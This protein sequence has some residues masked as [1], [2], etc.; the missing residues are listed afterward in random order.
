[1]TTIGEALRRAELALAPV[2]GDDARIEADVLL[3]HV[4]GVD[5]AHLL[6]S[7]ADDLPDERGT[8]F[9]ALV[10][11]RFAREPLS[12]VVGKTDFFSID[13]V[14]TPAALIPRWETEM[15]V[16]FALDEA[17]SRGR[18]VRV[19]DVGTGTGA[20]AVAIAANAL[21][22]EVTATD[23]STE[24]LA[25]ARINVDRNDA[26]ERVTLAHTDLLDGLGAFDV[27]VANLPYISETEWV[28]LPTEIHEHEPCEALVGGATGLEIIERLLLDAP[29]HLTAGGV[30]AAEIGDTHGNA[31][32]ALGR[33]CF[34]AAD[35]CVMKDLSGLDRML[36]VRT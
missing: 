15:L 32:L 29:S 9:H 2:S 14:C 25:L 33:A 16:G 3:A 22:V 36:V 6:A 5:R 23:S 28:D 20:I 27:I 10:A 21:N 4:L 17:R 26:V 35:V 11:R 34:P 30:L 19:A 1:M 31:A 12:Y 24:A 8:A 13:V 7:T 18:P